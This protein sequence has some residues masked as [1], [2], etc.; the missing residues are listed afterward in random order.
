MLA[1]KTKRI[2]VPITPHRCQSQ[3]IGSFLRRHAGRNTRLAKFYHDLGYPSLYSLLRPGEEEFIRLTDCLIAGDRGGHVLTIDYGA[4]YEPLTNSLSVDPSYDGIFVPPIPHHLMEE[5]P[6]CHGDWT[7]C[8]GRIDW[9][10]FV[11]FTNMAA[12][13]NELGYE[14]VWYGPQTFLEQMGESDVG[15]NEGILPN[16][17]RG[18]G[19][20][21]SFRGEGLKVSGYSV[22]QNIRVYCEILK[23]A[24]FYNPLL[25]QVFLSVLSSI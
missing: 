21:V 23:A 2:S 22:V 7:V 15:F 3:H 9:T 8:A 16:N 13:G 24:V 4:S 17:F 25:I 5:L 18:E 11:D 12:A 14:T 1:T 6:H 10:S 19:L 20:K